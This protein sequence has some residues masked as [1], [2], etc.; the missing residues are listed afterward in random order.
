MSKE[1][2]S[3]TISDKQ[4]NVCNSVIELKNDIHYSVNGLLLTILKGSVAWKPNGFDSEGKPVFERYVFTKDY[5]YQD[6]LSN[7]SVIAGYGF[8]TKFTSSILFITSSTKPEK[9]SGTL[10][11]NLNDNKIY[12]YHSSNTI[13][14]YE[15]KTAYTLPYV[16]MT[17]TSTEVTD[18]K[19]IEKVVVPLTENV[20]YVG[21]L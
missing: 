9:I 16:Y 3:L 17:Y 1:I 15:Y 4:I 11:L 12:R 20:T 7:C 13:D 5:T 18:I 10:W 6:N 2:Q 19:V 14:D 8:R 21:K